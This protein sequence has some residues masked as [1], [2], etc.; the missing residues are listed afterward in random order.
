MTAILIAAEC[1]AAYAGFIAVVMFLA[2]RLEVLTHA[3][4]STDDGSFGRVLADG[5]AQKTFDHGRGY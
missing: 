3:H 2:H 5:D 1:L 4:V